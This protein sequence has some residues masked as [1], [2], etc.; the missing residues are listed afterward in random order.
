MFS[1]ALGERTRGLAF[2]IGDDK[3]I[4]RQQHLTQMVVAV[5][6]DFGRVHALW[7]TSFNAFHYL[8]APR[9]HRIR[10]G[11]RSSGQ[12]VASTLEQIERASDVFAYG[13]GPGQ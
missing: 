11:P 1:P 12:T 3:I 9:Q 10:I 13:F 7:Y 2:E 4:L 5:M 6:A 8:R